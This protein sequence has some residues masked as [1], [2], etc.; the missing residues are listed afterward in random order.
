[1]E[2][3][4]VLDQLDFICRGRTGR[5]G[6]SDS[7]SVSVS[8]CIYLFTGVYRMREVLMGNR[9]RFVLMAHSL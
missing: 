6:I 8:V 9:S 5:E 1:M 3:E 7:V 4:R 2:Y